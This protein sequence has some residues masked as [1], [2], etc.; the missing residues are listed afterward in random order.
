V[1]VGGGCGGRCGSHE[2]YPSESLEEGGLSLFSDE[3]EVVLA[4]ALGYD[5]EEVAGGGIAEAINHD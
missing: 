4:F 1:E 5:G 2:G 3:G